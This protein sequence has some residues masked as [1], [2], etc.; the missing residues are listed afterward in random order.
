MSSTGTAP[1]EI[2]QGWSFAHFEK[3]AKVL[4]AFAFG[5]YVLGFLVS[6]QYLVLLGI[7][8]FSSLRPKFVLT[9]AWV[10]LLYLFSSLPGWVP[11]LYVYRFGRN[12]RINSWRIVGIAI[13]CIP[14]A[15]G[16]YLGLASMLMQSLHPWALHW[17]ITAFGWISMGFPWLI[18]AL[19]PD[20]VK[21]KSGAIAFG[22][23][24]C[25][26]LLVFSHGMAHDVYCQ[27]PEAYG[28]GRA[29]EVKLYFNKNGSQFWKGLDAS[30]CTQSNPESSGG[31]PVYI[32][33]QNEKDIMVGT[34]MTLWDAKGKRSFG[35][36]TINRNLLDG[37]V[38]VKPPDLP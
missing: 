5:L 29:V 6:N 8:D 13:L 23:L 31:T 26:T 21:N 10:F 33:Y 2:R 4:A 3:G 37:I 25:F 28:G 14:L 15:V 7:S 18:L 36:I 17:A 27:V 11:L 32:M 34:C 22:V 30:H 1:E 35:V 24:I 16:L 38:Q 9:G 12:R 20:D 19:Y